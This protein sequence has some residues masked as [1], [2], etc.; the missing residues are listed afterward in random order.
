MLAFFSSDL[1]TEVSM[2]LISADVTQRRYAAA[3]QQSVDRAQQL[4]QWAL[5]NLCDEQDH[6]HNLDFACQQTKCQ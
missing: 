6:G 3:T 1:L 5:K 4:T 2:G